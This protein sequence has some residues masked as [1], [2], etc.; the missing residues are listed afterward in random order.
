MVLGSF[1]SSSAFPLLQVAEKQERFCS[2]HYDEPFVGSRRSSRGLWKTLVPPAI[3]VLLSGVLLT[4]FM[5]MS[6]REESSLLWRRAAALT[7]LVTPVLLVVSIKR[8]FA[9][10]VSSLGV[11]LLCTVNQFVNRSVVAPDDGLCEFT[12]YDSFFE[13]KTYDLAAPYK[14]SFNY[15]LEV[16]AD[17]MNLLHRNIAHFGCVNIGHVRFGTRIL[18]RVLRNLKRVY[19]MVEDKRIAKRPVYTILTVP[20]YLNDSGLWMRQLGDALNHSG[21][22]LGG[23]IAVPH[24]SENDLIAGYACRIV[25]PMFL[26]APSIPEEYKS[27]NPYKYSM[28]LEHGAL[29][30]FASQD[31]PFSSLVRDCSLARKMVYV[32]QAG[33]IYLRHSV[34]CGR[35]TLSV[36]KRG[37]GVLSACEKSQTVFTYDN[38]KSYRYKLCTLK[39]NLTSLRYGILAVGINMDDTTNQCGQGSYAR[40]RVL[41]WLVDYFNSSFDSPDA[42][43]QCQRGP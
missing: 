4:F 12:F 35:S 18:K 5:I 20:M 2:G 23:L 19:D 6:R 21:L 15:F 37:R 36:G 34:R 22:P 8:P 39:K 32:R 38:G 16:Q 9:A 24:L 7:L 33:R 10:N 41:R 40:L 26:N 14:D 17:L 31:K 13:D 11:T 25:P 3:I 29:S 43:D 27:L 1:S 42:Y 28:T 30:K